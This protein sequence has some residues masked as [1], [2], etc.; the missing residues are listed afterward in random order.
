MVR[1]CWACGSEFHQ[2]EEVAL[3][4]FQEAVG[5][6]GLSWEGRSSLEHGVGRQPHSD[7]SGS[8]S[9]PQAC[10]V[11][12]R[13]VD[14]FWLA[15]RPLLSSQKH[16]T[17]WGPIAC[18]LASFWNNKLGLPVCHPSPF[19][20]RCCLK[21]LNS[22]PLINSFPASRAQGDQ[23]LSPRFPSSLLAG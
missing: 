4:D 1:R 20:Q 12:L 15:P 14:Y 3:G 6:Q 22:Q 18:Q 11:H 17:E 10:G 5:G 21:G 16:C 7:A 2:E 19:T 23:A 8:C 13:E 9:H